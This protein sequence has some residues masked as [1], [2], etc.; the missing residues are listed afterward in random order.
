MRFPRRSSAG[1]SPRGTSRL[2]RLGRR[3]ALGAASAALV[4]TGTFL[5]AAPPASAA[6]SPQW[7]VRLLGQPTNFSA[8]TEDSY[9]I[10]LT[11]VGTAPTVKSNNITI[12]DSLPPGLTATR[13]KLS[14]T[15]V[16]DA[17]PTLCTTAPVQC[18]YPKGNLSLPQIKPGESLDMI[19][20]LAVQPSLP[21][22]TVLTDSV[23]VSGGGAPNASATTSSNRVDPAPAAFGFQ[24]FELAA[25]SAAAAP[26]TQAG[27]H[28]YQ[29]TVGGS[30]NSKPDPIREGSPEGP[31]YFPLEEAKD[32]TVDLPPGMI[33]NP[34]ATKKCQLAEFYT[35]ECPAASQVGTIFLVPPYTIHS[36]IS[37]FYTGVPLY[38]LEPQPGHAATLGY[39]IVRSVPFILNA[40][41]RSGGDYSVVTT[42]Q[43]T[44]GVLLTVFSTTLWGVPADPSHNAERGQECQPG[45]VRNCRGLID[46]RWPTAF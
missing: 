12:T 30:F 44:P 18:V 34:Q 31:L 23:A 26:Y 28:P 16:E 17:G 6:A 39:L 1:K 19:V 40:G 24:D 9:L 46:V 2:H 8:S 38:N 36:A 27:G 42:A 43:D 22:G 3:V 35:A 13:V 21:A 20:Y 37:G 29:L 41:V 25:Q 14:L 33:G 7:R 11:N 5:L 45:F 4:V 32:I 15:G 10:V